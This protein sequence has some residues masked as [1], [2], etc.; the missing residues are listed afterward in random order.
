MTEQDGPWSAQTIPRHLAEA[1]LPPALRSQFSDHAATVLKAT[2][3]NLPVGGALVT[4][5]IGVII[6]NLREER[7]VAYLAG[8]ARKVEATGRTLEQLQ[9]ELTP[10]KAALFED[11]ANGAVKA[12]TAGRIEQLVA[13]VAQGLGAGGREAEDQRSLVRLLNDLTDTDLRYLMNWVKRYNEDE[14]WRRA[15]GFH[16]EFQSQPVEFQF[17][18]NTLTLNQPVPVGDVMDEI[19]EM[20][21]QGR[22]E[23]LGLLER[24]VIQAREGEQRRGERFEYDI[25]VSEAGMA[26]LRKLGLTGDDDERAHKWRT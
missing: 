20:S 25:N 24:R 21:V 1:D 13:L 15:H 19:A 26:L 22:L 12:T 23:S 8:L 17:G 9:A 10:E 2:L 16:V 4:E 7:I 3:G 5:L 18:P 6:P 14:D 11:G